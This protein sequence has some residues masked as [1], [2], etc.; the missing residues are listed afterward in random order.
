MQREKFGD[1][2]PINLGFSLTTFRVTITLETNW[3]LDLTPSNFGNLIGFEQKDSKRQTQHWPQSS[4]PQS[5]YG[6]VERS[7]RSHK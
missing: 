2:F 1:K 7:L 4:K 5:R 3:Q 6:Y